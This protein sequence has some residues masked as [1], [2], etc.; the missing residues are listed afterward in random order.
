MYNT[1]TYNLYKTHTKTNFYIISNTNQTGYVTNKK[2]YNDP[3]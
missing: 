2:L 3:T 1:Y